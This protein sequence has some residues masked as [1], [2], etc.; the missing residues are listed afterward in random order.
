MPDAQP[1]RTKAGSARKP[2]YAGGLRFECQKCGHCCRGEPGVVWVSRCEVGQISAHLGI[3]TKE[4]RKKYLRRVGFEFSLK[5]HDDGD[6]V[7]FRNGCVAYPVRPAQCQSFPFW[8]E[9]LRNREWYDE[10]VSDCPG[11]IGKRRVGKEWSSR[12]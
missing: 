9:A 8:P 6:C 5:E 12:W 1:K 7:L 4:F 10:V 11:K 2:W 3:S